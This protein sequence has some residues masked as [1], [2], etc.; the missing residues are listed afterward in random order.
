MTN[1]VSGDFTVK[2]S[3]LFDYLRLLKESENIKIEPSSCAAFEGPVKLL[4]YDSCRKYCAENG[5][6]EENL[7]N[8]VQIC[9]ATGGNL[10]PEEIYKEYFN[11]R[12]NK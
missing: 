11:T 8:S 3:L 1:L 7:K 2:D 4:G 10:V 12:L 6:F 5:L 9:W